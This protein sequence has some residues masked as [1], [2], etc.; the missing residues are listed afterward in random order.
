MDSSYDTP[1]GAISPIEPTS[2]L[3]PHP[4]GAAAQ[5]P[6]AEPEVPVSLPV[7]SAALVVTRGPLQGERFELTAGRASLGRHP[8]CDI[9]LDDSTVSRRHAEVREEG[10]GYVIVDTGSLNGTYVNRQPVDRAQLADGY[11]IWIGKF[12]LSFH[13]P[14][15]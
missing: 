5:P 14:E 11:V 12:R 15:A 7:T 4:A 1:D 2:R 10:G 6:V 9:V 3:I 13:L 8:E